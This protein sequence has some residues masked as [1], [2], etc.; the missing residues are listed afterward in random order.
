[1][2]T[3]RFGENLLREGDHAGAEDLLRRA[4]EATTSDEEL[5]E[6]LESSSS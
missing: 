3:I 5:Q 1:V 4:F 2:R 6:L